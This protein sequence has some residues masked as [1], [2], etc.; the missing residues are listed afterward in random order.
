MGDVVK[1][2]AVHHGATRLAD[3]AAGGFPLQ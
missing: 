2:L 3:P 1:F